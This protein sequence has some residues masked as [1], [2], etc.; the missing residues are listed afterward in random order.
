MYIVDINKYY[1]RCVVVSECL[2]VNVVIHIWYTIV[3]Q[4]TFVLSFLYPITMCK[5]NYSS[6]LTI[7][8]PPP[9]HLIFIFQAIFSLCSSC[10]L[11]NSS[12]NHI[13]SWLFVSHCCSVYPSFLHGWLLH[14][15]FCTTSS[16]GA[17]NIML[18]TKHHIIYAWYFHKISMCRCILPILLPV[19]NSANWCNVACWVDLAVSANPSLL[20]VHMY[21]LIK[22]HGLFHHIYNRLFDPV[23]LC[24]L[25]RSIKVHKIIYDYSR[26]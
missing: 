11:L 4:E 12:T 25:I 18:W 19:T 8:P 10:L 22:D 23:F 6:F 7:D 13:L 26:W 9:N 5:C 14:V 17:I 21:P 24:P 2:F 15:L 3:C 16:C 20:C 1:G